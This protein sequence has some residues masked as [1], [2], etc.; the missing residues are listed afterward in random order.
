MF[1]DSEGE[2][3]LVWESVIEIWICKSGSLI[4]YDMIFLLELL[5]FMFWIR[6]F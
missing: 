6:L 3:K 1:S 2:V 4:C 5:C